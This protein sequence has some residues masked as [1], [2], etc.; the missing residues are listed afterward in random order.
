[1]IDKVDRNVIAKFKGVDGAV[2]ERMVTAF[3]SLA[4]LY[5]EYVE[6]AEAGPSANNLSQKGVVLRIANAVEAGVAKAIRGLDKF[7][8][9]GCR[10]DG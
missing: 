3:E 2:R 5:A 1:M 7:A 10:P 6:A 8:A 9:S 4:A